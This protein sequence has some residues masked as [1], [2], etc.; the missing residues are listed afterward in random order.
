MSDAKLHPKPVI[1]KSFEQTQ[2][3]I[4]G[5]CKGNKYVFDDES[6]DFIS[7]PLCLGEGILHRVTEGSVKLFTVK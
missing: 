4:C 2:V 1:E 5:S 3:V 7:C 6:L